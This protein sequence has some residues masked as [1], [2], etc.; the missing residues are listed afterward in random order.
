MKQDSGW[1]W[2]SLA[3]GVLFVCGVLAAM[4][5][6]VLVRPT[7]RTPPVDIY[8]LMLDV[9]VLPRGWE[10]CAG[11]GVIPKPERAETESL[12]VGFCPPDFD[13]LGGTHQEVYAYRNE[14][15]A[16]SVYSGEFQ[17]SEFPKGN[18][19]TP[20][21]VPEEWSYQSPVADRFKFA[22]G[23]PDFPPQLQGT[24]CVAVAQY[25]EYVSVLVTN[26]S[27]GEMTLQD[28][29]RILVAID[30]RMAFYLG[31]EAE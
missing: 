23:E 13:G 14:V 8:D 5:T 18:M 9:S 1:H 7:R 17:A 16:A 10:L 19:I 21:A 28:V 11:P 4:R 22:C 29:E 30:E 15:A 6:A 31:N 2:T 27:P 12:L 3:I 26:P 20:W 24:V 25:D